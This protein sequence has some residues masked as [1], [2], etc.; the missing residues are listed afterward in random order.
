MDSSK[1]LF[2]MLKKKK[3]CKIKVDRDGKFYS[4]NKGRVQV[5]FD[6]RCGLGNLW[7]CLEGRIWFFR[8]GFLL[9]VGIKGREVVSY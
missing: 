3:S 4:V 7:D 8:V 5:C 6:Q 9:K 1:L 2:E